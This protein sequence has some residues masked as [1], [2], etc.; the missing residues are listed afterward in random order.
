MEASE[1]FGPAIVAAEREGLID[2]ALKRRVV[3]A[4]FDLW[5]IERRLKF[6]RKTADEIEIGLNRMAVWEIYA[7]MPVSARLGQA[8]PEVDSDQHRDKDIT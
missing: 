7:P 4:A 8:A 3:A 2:E 5:Q 6:D 1:S